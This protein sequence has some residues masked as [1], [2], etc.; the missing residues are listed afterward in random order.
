LL[1]ILASTV[2]AEPESDG[3]RSASPTWRTGVAS[4]HPASSGPRKKIR[5]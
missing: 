5:T 4:I 2:T 1:A 3:S